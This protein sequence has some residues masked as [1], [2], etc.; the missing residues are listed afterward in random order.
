[1]IQRFDIEQ[2]MQVE[3]GQQLALVANPNK[4]K[5]VIE[6]QESQAREIQVGQ[7]AVIDTRTSGTVEAVVSRI[8]PNVERGIVKVDVSFPNGLPAGVRADQ[9]IQGTIELQRLTDV[10]FVDRPTLVKEGMLTSVFKVNQEGNRADRLTVQFGRSS[11]TLI[12]IVEG[13]KP[14]DQIILSDLSRF[15]EES[16]LEIR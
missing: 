4:L 1:V 11:V 13:L 3:V 15:E 12:E 16:A 7:K 5:A 6:I 2:G 10:V 8:D 14:G 9:T